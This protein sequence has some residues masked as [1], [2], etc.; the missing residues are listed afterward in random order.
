MISL[1]HFVDLAITQARIV[2][3]APWRIPTNLSWNGLFSLPT[4]HQDGSGDRSVILS[5]M[6]SPWWWWMHTAAFSLLFRNESRLKF[7][8]WIVFASHFVAD[9]QHRRLVA[10]DMVCPGLWLHYWASNELSD[11]V[12]FVVHVDRHQVH[13]GV[14]RPQRYTADNN[15]ICESPEVGRIRKSWTSDPNKCQLLI[16][17][18]GKPLKC[19]SCFQAQL[20]LEK[21]FVT[22]E[23]CE[24][25]KCTSTMIAGGVSVLCDAVLFWSFRHPVWC[26]VCFHLEHYFDIFLKHF[27]SSEAAVFFLGELF[28]WS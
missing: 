22:S 7:P 13:P 20:C 2:C 8:L 21:P 24:N 15:D 16:F 4:Q 27:Y 18:S 17:I 1:Q 23:R 10:W 19:A 26:F 28:F 11:Q 6:A 25:H 12:C 5:C 14:R 9:G 3:G